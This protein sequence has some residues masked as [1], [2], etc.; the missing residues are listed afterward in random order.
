MY[1]HPSLDHVIDAIVSHPHHD[2][3]ILQIPSGH[4]LET[5]DRFSHASN[6][7]VVVTLP[8][9]LNRFD[10]HSADHLLQ[11]YHHLVPRAH[12]VS[13]DDLLNLLVS[14][15]TEILTS[16][17]QL[18]VSADLNPLILQLIQ[19]SSIKW[20]QRIIISLSPVLA[21]LT[22]IV[23]TAPVY[24]VDLP[25][26]PIELR[27][28]TET[29][30]LNDPHILEQT[31]SL[32]ATLH[33]SATEGD[34]I[35]FAATPVDA[36]SV[37]KSLTQMQLPQAAIVPV[38]KLITDWDLL[39]QPL[40]P[41]EPEP[42]EFLPPLRKIYVTTNPWSELIPNNSVS[43]IIDTLIELYATQSPLGA[44]RWIRGYETQTQAEQ[45]SGRL[46]MTRPG[47]AYRLGRPELLKPVRL[48]P[49]VSPREIVTIIEAHLDPRSLPAINEASGRQMN[50]L[51][52]QMIHL[53]LLEQNESHLSITDA[54]KFISSLPLSLRHGT[55]LW[56]WYRYGYPIFPGLAIM[57]MLDVAVSGT[58][59]VQ[60]P[61]KR[62]DQDRTAYSVDVDV[63]Q[64][65]FYQNFGGYSD[66]A[67][68]LNVV[69][70]LFNAIGGPDGTSTDTFTWCQHYRVNY[71]KIQ[72]V[73]ALIHD[74]RQ[75]ITQMNI[76]CPTGPFTTTNVLEQLRPILAEVNADWLMNLELVASIP[77]YR[78][79]QGRDYR[80][81]MLTAT[82]NFSLNPPVFII[83]LVVTEI[84][85]TYT[86]GSGI[87]PTIINLAIDVP[88][89]DVSNILEQPKTSFQQ[90]RVDEAIHLIASTTPSST[91]KDPS[92]PSDQS[93]T[94]I[95]THAET[96]EP[97]L[98]RRTRSRSQTRRSPN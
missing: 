32:V 26:H 28:L 92:A 3:V 83:A 60:L 21:E 14:T 29:R 63:A 96:P 9:S 44:S 50:S 72:E 55:V 61:D 13:S 5:V 77:H 10:I 46:G 94:S 57:A 82:N 20:P 89:N 33:S 36:Q 80:L 71:A 27:Y 43:L 52:D 19:S 37:F 81:E 16:A 86:H 31:A 1:H 64:R 18:L 22:S 25:R 54:G 2:L 93:A 76:N 73:L 48:P 23:P 67:T 45:R 74:S 17:T 75:I 97:R 4:F 62:L 34:F 12:W 91:E 79:R 42:N 69:G 51:I 84:I 30:G 24:Q 98:P 66:V 7:H 87:Q 41:T 58:T 11:A 56:R 88:V 95:T 78:D 35:V 85:E 47:L 6:A 40:S 38:F 59:F 49:P 65:Q 53:G 8:T 70:A 39:R 68:L 15:D 90:I